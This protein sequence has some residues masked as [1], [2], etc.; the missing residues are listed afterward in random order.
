[1]SGAVGEEDGVDEQVR[2]VEERVVPGEIIRADH[3]RRAVL[4]GETP[5]QRGLA[6]GAVAVDGQHGA[7]REVEAS[8][9]VGSS[10]SSRRGF[11][12]SAIAIITRCRIPPEN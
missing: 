5:G 1:M 4:G 8:A 2:P 12:S 9:V 11:A 7:G 3:A 10:A 6:A